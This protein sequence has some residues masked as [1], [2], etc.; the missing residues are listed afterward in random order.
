[1]S[2][3]CSKAILNTAVAFMLYE[4]RLKVIFRNL[5]SWGFGRT[6]FGISGT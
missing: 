2:L 6:T 1:M 3:I 4:D 5:V